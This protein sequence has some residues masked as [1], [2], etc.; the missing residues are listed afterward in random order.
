LS[1]LAVLK[2]FPLGAQRLSR[3]LTEYK[4]PRQAERKQV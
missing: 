3:K 1:L 2:W 4:K